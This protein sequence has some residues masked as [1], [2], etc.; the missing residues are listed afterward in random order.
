[1]SQV[2]VKSVKPGSVGELAGLRPGDVLAAVYGVSI[3]SRSQLID[4]MKEEAK[5]HDSLT[6]VIERAED[7]LELSLPEPSDSLGC[8]VKDESGDNAEQKSNLGTGR[9]YALGII[10]ILSLIPGLYFLFYMPSETVNLHRLTVGQT[11]AIIGALFIAA[12]WRPKSAT[13]IK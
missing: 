13:R 1:M 4:T 7:R 12:E 2:I 11:L 6:M 10:G 5:K 3:Q 9:S 8:V